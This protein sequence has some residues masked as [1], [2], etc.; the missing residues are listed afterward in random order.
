MISLR[1]HLPANQVND[2][3]FMNLDWMPTLAGLCELKIQPKNIDG[4]DMSQ[5]IKNPKAFSPRKGGF[6]K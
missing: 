6:C 4:L 3:F 1:D 2:Q 5:M